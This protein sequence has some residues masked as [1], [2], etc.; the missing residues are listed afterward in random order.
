VLLSQLCDEP[1]IFVG[2]SSAQ[3]VIEMN[4]GENNANLLAQF[5]QQTE[6]SD[7]VRAA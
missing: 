2:L 3:L 6:Q 1:L 5:E 7:R 4:Q